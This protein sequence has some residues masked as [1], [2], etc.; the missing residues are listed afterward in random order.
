M[1]RSVRRRAWVATL[2]AAVAIIAGQ[3]VNAAP[4]GA[5][6]LP[7]FA[8]HSVSFHSAATENVTVSSAIPSGSV[9]FGR[10]RA[11]LMSDV[12]SVS[13]TNSTGSPVTVHDFT[14]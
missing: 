3:A 13:F 5:E 11:N 2:T 1:H 12:A 6:A 14:L 10:V 7:R 4:V 8:H 9:N